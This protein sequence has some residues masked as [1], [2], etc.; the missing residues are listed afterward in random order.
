MQIDTWTRIR[1]ASGTEHNFLTSIWSERFLITR[2]GFLLFV[3][4]HV[5]C[6]FCWFITV[7]R[8]HRVF[9]FHFVFI[10]SERY[11]VLIVF[12]S[13]FSAFSN[14]AIVIISRK[15]WRFF[16]QPVAFEICLTRWVLHAFEWQELSACLELYRQMARQTR[17]ALAEDSFVQVNW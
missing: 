14:Y 16:I 17:L 7:A 5:L 6:D 1:S 8:W 13:C 9:S 12:L 4:Y 3:G 11:C 10:S 2:V 15:R